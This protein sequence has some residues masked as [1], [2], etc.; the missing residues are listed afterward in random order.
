MHKPSIVL[1]FL[2][3]T[4]GF[5]CFSK[6]AKKAEVAE[7]LVEKYSLEPPDQLVLFGNKRVSFSFYAWAYYKPKPTKTNVKN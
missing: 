6:G 5:G 2:G 1:L 7:N 4:L 3:V